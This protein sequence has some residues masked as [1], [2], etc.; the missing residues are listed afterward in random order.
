[1]PLIVQKFGGTSVGS[2]ERIHHVAEKIIEAKNEGNQIVVVVSAMSGE[3]NRLV[4]LATQIDSVPNARELD[5][6]LTAGEQVSMALLAMTL[7]KLGYEATSMTGYQAKIHTD[8]NHNNAAIERID[9]APIQALLDDN[10]IVI[11]AGFQGFNAK[12]D[13]TTL[14][15]GGSDTTA[16]ALAGALGAKECQIYTDVDGVYSCDPRVVKQ[17]KKL[18]TLDFPSMEEMARRGAKVL[19]LPCVQYAWQHNV[20][21]RVLSSFEQGE[22]TLIAGNQCLN[23]IAGIAIQRDM[24][25]IEC[26]NEDLPS[27]ISQCQL[28]GIEVCSVIEETERAALIIK[29]DISAKLKLVF[30]EKIRNSEQVSL[31]TVV[32]SRTQE[33]VVSSHGLLSEG[34][35]DV[36]HH[37]LQ[38]QSL[39]LVISPTQVDMA[40]NI[41]HNAYI[42]ARETQGYPKKEVHFG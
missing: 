37:L 25:R 5:V 11:V 32:G 17:S 9:T 1:M 7:H 19:H 33:I 27:F 30:D 3:T 10:Q 24:V 6:L 13:I 40:A 31:L 41:L 14:G 22:G 20:P 39:T 4:N 38:Q 12:G 21:L 26:L 16:V 29:Q 8:S 34:E 2:I 18:D 23:D 35:I 28:L 42:V 36:Q 15:R